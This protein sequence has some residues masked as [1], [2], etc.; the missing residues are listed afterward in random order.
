MAFILTF[1]GAV[2][3]L[4]LGII[5]GAAGVIFRLVSKEIARRRKERLPTFY[6]NFVVKN[7]DEIISSEVEARDK[8]SKEKSKTHVNLDPLHFKVIATKEIAHKV[9]KDDKFMLQLSTKVAEGMKYKFTPQKIDAVGEG[10]KKKN[11]NN[12]NNVPS[13]GLAETYIN[14]LVSSFG[15]QFAS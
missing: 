6:V 11:N 3:C 13:Y 10:E 5:V 4:L 9:V 7:K 12:N 8:K 1:L 2:F 15:C 14:S